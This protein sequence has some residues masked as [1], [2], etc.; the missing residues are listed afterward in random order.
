MFVD[1]KIVG[2]IRI[3]STATNAFAPRIFRSRGHTNRRWRPDL[4]EDAAYESV[5]ADV[6]RLRR[7]LHRE[8]RR[9]QARLAA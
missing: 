2:I 7:E 1:S 4:A 6:P 8:Y 9:L 5:A 3:E